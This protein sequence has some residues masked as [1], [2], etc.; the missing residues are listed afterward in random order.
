ME[1][2][3]LQRE[4]GLTYDAL[5]PYHVNSIG[6]RHWLLGFRDWRPRSGDIG[7]WHLSKHLQRIYASTDVS[8]MAALLRPLCTILFH[9]Q[10]SE[11]ILNK[12]FFASLHCRHHISIRG[13]YLRNNSK[14]YSQQTGPWTVSKQQRNLFNHRKTHIHS[15][16][17]AHRNQYTD[18][19]RINFFYSSSFNAMQSL[20]DQLG[21]WQPLRQ[22][23]CLNNSTLQSN[24][25]RPPW[26]LTQG[27]RIQVS[28][29]G[30]RPRCGR[31]ATSMVTRRRKGRTIMNFLDKSTSST[32][33]SFKLN[34]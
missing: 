15:Q 34:S 31:V 8:N 28:P 9:S 30:H 10:K 2:K 18:G 24:N 13:Y 16:H 19:L 4:C 22:G 6:L 21:I 14:P 5:L 33:G 27:R 32:N 29:S 26:H 25:R 17:R 7:Q 11:S 20:N 1:S 12:R 23:V 3:I